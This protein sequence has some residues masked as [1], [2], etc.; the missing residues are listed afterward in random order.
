MSDLPPMRDAPTVKSVLD[1]LVRRKV[2]T[3]ESDVA[4]EENDAARVGDR[5][6]CGIAR[7]EDGFCAH[8][9]GHPIYVPPL[10][11]EIAARPTE[12]DKEMLAGIYDGVM[13][14][15]GEPLGASLIDCAWS[16]PLTLRVWDGMD[17]CWTDCA[18]GDAE[19]MLR[20]WYEKTDGGTKNTNGTDSIDYYRLFPA[21]TRM[22]WNGDE[23]RE[24]FRASG[25]FENEP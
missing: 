2:I 5:T 6:C 12:I 25:D 22:H 18:T 4:A 13:H 23:G 16:K 24:M 14:R 11:E 1:M 20:L 7:D 19:K 17:G 9:P 21:D 8:R 3:R 15:Y 10:A